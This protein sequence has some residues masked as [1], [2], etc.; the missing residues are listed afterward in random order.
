MASYI[1]FDVII[2]FLFVK[3]TKWRDFIFVPEVQLTIVWQED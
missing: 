3:I 1:L 2:C